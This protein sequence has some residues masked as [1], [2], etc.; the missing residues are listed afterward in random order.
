M[1]RE[2]GLQFIGQSIKNDVDMAMVADAIEAISTE[3]CEDC[4]SRQATITAIKDYFH[5]DYYQRTSIQ[6]CRDD[7]IEDVLTKLPSVQP[8]QRIGHWVTTKKEKISY[9]EC[10]NCAALYPITETTY[11]FSDAKFCPNCGAKMSENPTGSESED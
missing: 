4:V 3:P 7:F 6:D 1:T 5:D 11:V 10:S 9:A 2:E 8:K